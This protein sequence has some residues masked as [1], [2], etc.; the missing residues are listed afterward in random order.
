MKASS[1]GLILYNDYATTHCAVAH[2]SVLQAYTTISNQQAGSHL[3]PTI[4]SIL[5]ESHITL[6]HCDYI[7]AHQG[8]APFTT[9]RSVITTANGLSYASNR[10]LI[11]VDGL[12]ALAYHA[13][14]PNCTHTLVLLYAF[15][16]DVYYGLYDERGT[17]IL[18][19]WAPFDQFHEQ[20]QQY[21]QNQSHTIDIYCVGNAVINHY[22]TLTSQTIYNAVIPEPIPYYADM[23]H[24]VYLAHQHWQAKETHTMLTPL[25][26]KQSQAYI[27]P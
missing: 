10:P 4:A 26:L 16:N 12:R 9:L 21:A 14:D 5:D 7:A 23:K 24:I 2:N 17:A 8:P 25:Y 15:R 13:H 22:E 11:G 18:Y 3:V 6:D 20:L 1:T 27:H 19:G